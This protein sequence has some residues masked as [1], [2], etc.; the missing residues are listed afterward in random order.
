MLRVC[1]LFFGLVLLFP[2]PVL[3]Q[4]NPAGVTEERLLEILEGKEPESVEEL[5]A[6][7]KHV[8]EMLGKVVPATVGVRVGGNAGSGVIITEDGYILTAGHVSGKPNQNAFV[9]MPDGTQYRAKTLGANQGIDSGLMKITKKGKYPYVEMGT[10]KELTRGKWIIALGHPGGYVK[11]REPVLRLGRILV[12][13]T[14]YLQTDCTLVGGDSGGPLFDLD[15]KVIGI[16]SRI[17]RSIDTNIHVPVDTYGETWDRLVAAE[18][19][20]GRTFAQAT[21]PAGGPYLGLGI[22]IEEKKVIISRIEEGGPADKAGLKVDDVLLELKKRKIVDS[23]SLRITIKDL[24]PRDKVKIK[25]AR[26]D[27]TVETDITIGRRK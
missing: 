3:A 20:G 5:K 16:H 7:Q 19:W 6:M 12:N 21:R 10:S 24:K 23:D 26:G 25:Y 14:R 4:D 15:G 18:E 9:I 1:C 27:T 22:K 17:N 2:F 13:N 11:G 8:Q